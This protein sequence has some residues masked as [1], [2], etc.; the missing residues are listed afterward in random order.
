MTRLAEALGLD[1]TTLTRN[2]RALVDRGLIA[3][4]D[5]EDRR[6]RLVALTARG[7]RSLSEALGLWKQAQATVEERFGHGRLQGL[8]AD[9]E[10]HLF[11]TYTDADGKVSKPS[12]PF[13]FKLKDR[14]GYK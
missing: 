7:K 8:H 14:F 5:G 10:F 1:R 4:V 2:M 13:A 3:V 11:V 6:T 12:A 9:T